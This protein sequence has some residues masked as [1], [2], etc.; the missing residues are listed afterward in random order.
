MIPRKL[1]MRSNRSEKTSGTAPRVVLL[2]LLLA[3][4]LLPACGG[5]PGGGDPGGTS[6]GA[7]V[8]SNAYFARPIFDVN[9]KL[10]KIVNPASLFEVDAITGVPLQGFP[11]PLTPGQSLNNLVSFNFEQIQDPLTPQVPLI[12]RNAVVVLEFTNPV[13]EV[14]LL[15]DDSDPENPNLLS[16]LSPVQALR[17]DG[18][19]IPVR[20]WVDGKRIILSAILTTSSGWEAS[21]LTFDALGN[22]VEDPTGNVRLVVNNNIGAPLLD[23]GAA[24]LEPRADLLGATLNPVPFN[25]GNSQLDAILQQTA[26]GTVGFN[27]FLPDLSAPRIVRAVELEGA[28]SSIGASVVGPDVLVEIV[29]ASL[30]EAPNTTANGGFG[31]WANSLMEITSAGDV[32]TKY[33]VL[34][35]FDNAVPPNDP[36]FRLKPGETLDPLVAPGD[37][38]RLVRTEYFEPIPPPL[39]VDPLD[40]AAVTVDPGAIPRDPDDPQDELNHDLRYFLHVYDEDDAPRTDVWNPLTGTFLAIP[41]RSKV[42]LQFNESM[43][44]DSFASYE[45]FYVTD[46]AVQKDDPAFLDMRI[47][48]IET[49]DNNREVRFAPFLE[50]QVDPAAS[51]FIGFGGTPASLKLVMR[52]SPEQSDIDALVE[53]ISADQLDDIADLDLTGV[54]GITD[55]GGRGL[56]LPR[57][58]LDA[59]DPVNFLLEQSSVGRGPFSP[60]VDFQ[61]V[62]QTQASEDPDYGVIVHR[63]MGQPTT[64][65]FTPEPGEVADTVQKGIEYYDYPPET[66]AG[67]DV[68]RRF[69]YGPQL[70]DLGLNIPGRLSGAPAA[71]IEH[72]IDDFN[73]PKASQF[74]S[75]NNQDFLT[76]LGFGVNNPVVAPF[77]ARFQHL[78][79]AG[80]A[81]PAWFDFNGVSLDLIGLAWSPLLNLQ[82][83]GLISTTIDSFEILVGLAST[84]KGL[85]PNTNQNNGIPSQGNSG[86]RQHFD[87]NLLEWASNC[88][89]LDAIDIGLKPFVDGQVGLTTVVKEGTPHS[90]QQNQ[91]FTPA[92]AAGK[93]SGFNPYLNYPAFNSGV[94]PFF[95]DQNAVGYP[96]DSRFAMLL[97]YRLRPNLVPQASNVYR[98][99]PGI[100]T[101]VLPRFRTWTQGQDALAW[102]VP[103]MTIGNQQNNHWRSGAGGPLIEPGGTLAAGSQN[104]QLPGLPVPPGTGPLFPSPPYGNG[105]P[106]IP[107]DPDDWSYILPPLAACAPVEVPAQKEPDSTKPNFQGGP[108]TPP[109]YPRSNTDPD[110]NFYFA[111][112]D[113]AYP[114]PNLNCYPGPAGI[115]P[116]SWYGYG[117]LLNTGCA[118]GVPIYPNYALRPGEYGDNSRYYMLWRYRKRVSVIESPTIE[119][120]SPSGRVRYLRPII[121][122]PLAETAPGA[123]LS[124]EFRTS[125]LLDY[126][127]P[128]LES[129]YISPDD[130]DLSDELSGFDSD[131]VYVKFRASMGVASGQNQGPSIDIVIIPYEKLP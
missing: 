33:V 20:A 9:G 127:V 64:A 54:K 25:P 125:S 124:V 77:G 94:D 59:G 39:P 82:G 45:S 58:L 43:D 131:R 11:K 108:P 106:P 27:G 6:G 75:P 62:F 115:P 119:A 57:A 129:G 87:C 117:G 100:L 66:D 122:P 49:A 22:V 42:G 4:G 14:S 97:E 65:A 78:Y 112:G 32:V 72:L 68:T 28:I 34:D 76:S 92:N 71:A 61:V 111:T 38:Y 40:L 69:V 47:G 126:A 103:N 121:D 18:S 98:F 31:E 44:P 101:S 7:F 10:A 56:G 85:G 29:D 21:P 110:M 130:P 13:F 35:N 116:T 105:Q 15:L 41:P 70:L 67:G 52:T 3:V 104:G 51:Q 113:L 23:I 102:G 114:A 99:S 89:K 60:A 84:N 17:K 120:R 12:P 93:S 83:G 128:I 91:L 79:R 80:D 46:F 55:L 50:D 63:F 88:C 96:Y 109:P 95:D 5:G 90:M 74:A 53:G 48:I 86:M 107:L 24:I 73:K 37:S 36:T 118:V 1:G 8:L 16:P 30:P 81:S 26:N 19:K 123:G 2:S